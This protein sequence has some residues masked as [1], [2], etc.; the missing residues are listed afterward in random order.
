MGKITKIQCIIHSNQSIL[1][2]NIMKIG[3]NYHKKYSFVDHNPLII[4]DYVG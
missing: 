1:F 3:A 2:I 4:S